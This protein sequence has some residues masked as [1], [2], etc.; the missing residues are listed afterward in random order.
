MTEKDLST[1]TMIIPTFN[2][3]EYFQRLIRYY[4]SKNT[5]MFFLILDT[6]DPEIA[7]S[8]QKASL[9]LG[10]TARY[11]QLSPSIPVIEK[12]AEGVGLVK[13]PYCVFCADDDL[14][15]IDGLEHCL[16]FLHKNNEFVCSDGIYLNFI[17][18]K[19]KVHLNVEYSGKAI[20]ANH[21]VARVFGLFQKYESPFYGVSKTSQVKKVYESI[22]GVSTNCFIELFQ[23]VATLLLG[24]KQ[25]LPVL[26]GARQGGEAAEAGRGQWQSHDWYAESPTEVIKY[27][28]LYR[29]EL[30]RFYERNIQNFPLARDEFDRSMDLAHTVFLV[31]GC[32]P[33]HFYEKLQMHWPEDPFQKFESDK[34]DLLHQLRKPMYRTWGGINERLI[35]KL[36]TGLAKVPAW[37]QLKRFNQRVNRR[38]NKSWNC[39][40]PSSVRWL[41]TSD[42]FRKAYL[43]LCKYLG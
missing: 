10:N 32:S 24:K 3:P 35:A 7:K 25:R 14:I 6:S 37:V 40:L 30:W 39:I 41:A 31:T 23:A 8:N 29:E 16:D 28:L 13:T 21:P 26:Y 36:K 38:T 33:Q 27:Y 15:F 1:L 9:M 34:D 22:R 18:Q 20:H 2:R 43:E 17:T 12:F 5:N 42:D 11:I 19:N 4:A